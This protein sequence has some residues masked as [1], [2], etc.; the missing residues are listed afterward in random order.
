MKG[1]TYEGRKKKRAILII[2]VSTFFGL[3]YPVLSREFGDKFAF[4]NGITIGFLGGS[5]ISIFELYIFNPLNKRIGFIKKL[6][7]KSIVYLI[8]FVLLIVLLIAFTGS[9]ET[10]TSFIKYL[11]GEEMQYFIFEEDFFL[12]LQYTLFLTSAIIFT[13][14]MSRKMGQK[15]LWNFVTG[16]Y[17]E[18]KEVE[19]IF[20]FLD[21]NHSTVIADKLGDVQ[22]NYLLNDVFFDL[23]SS[24]LSTY[25][26]IYRYVGDEIVITWKMN[27]GLKYANCFRTFF[28]SKY[29]I[30]SNREKYLTKYGFVP[31]F[32][33]GY[34]CGKVI[35]GEIGDVKSQISYSGNV[36]YIT[37][38]IEKLC[39]KIDKEILVSEE[40][41][42]RISLPEIYEMKLAGAIDQ[43]DDISMDL[44]TISEIDMA[45][46]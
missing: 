3:I 40:L 10:K 21:L 43:D 12:I 18:P 29:A 14:Q 35:V 44:Y 41:I 26:E 30:R 32:S 36:L 15:V 25:G 17:R 16:K 9:I 8:F 38:S 23:T 39:K 37:S 19:R 46:V 1:H 22:Y 7:F 5:F 28:Q 33:A 31:T 45:N 4:I 2:G 42:K 27:K 34:H 11:T 20:M 24:I 13:H 6:I